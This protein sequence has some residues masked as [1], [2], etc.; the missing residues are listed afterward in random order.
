MVRNSINSRFRPRRRRMVRSKRAPVVPLTSATQTPS[1]ISVSLTLPSIQ[2]YPRLAVYQSSEQPTAI[3]RTIEVRQPNADDKMIA[4]IVRLGVAV[5]RRYPKESAA[6]AAG[7]CIAAL[8]DAVR[9]N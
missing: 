5:A 3:S 2:V 4:D 1:P 7:F 9:N 8:I 6:F